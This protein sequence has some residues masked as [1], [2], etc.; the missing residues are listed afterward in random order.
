MITLFH[1]LGVVFVAMA[2]QRPHVDDMMIG[3]VGTFQLLAFGL[4]SSK[5]YASISVGRFEINGC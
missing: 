3:Y 4:P 2:L 5:M 1:N